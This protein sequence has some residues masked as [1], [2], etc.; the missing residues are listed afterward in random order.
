MNS[1]KAAKPRPSLEAGEARLFQLETEEFLRN[2]AQAR[3][4]ED[5]VGPSGGQAAR[6]ADDEPPLKAADVGP[7]SRAAEEGQ[8][9]RAADVGQP[10]RAA[11]EGQP[12]RAAGGKKDGRRGTVEEPPIFPMKRAEA[13][14]VE[15]NGR[16]GALGHLEVYVFDSKQSHFHV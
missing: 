9:L 12:L 14:Q 2:S 7:P 16:Q 3:A 13:K 1:G 8:P 4:G 11:E 6:S 5:Y 10:S 15:K